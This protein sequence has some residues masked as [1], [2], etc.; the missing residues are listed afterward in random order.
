[1]RDYTTGTREQWLCA[2]LELL[3]AEK[4]YARQGDELGRR[5]LQALSWVKH[6]AKVL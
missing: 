3:H 6:D 5:R 4:E 2:R 1:M